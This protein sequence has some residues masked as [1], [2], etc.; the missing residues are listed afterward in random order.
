MDEQK[1]KEEEV[2]ELQTSQAHLRI[3][4]GTLESSVAQLQDELQQSNALLETM[5]AQGVAVDVVVL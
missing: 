2:A 5:Q 1:E 3:Q 4:V